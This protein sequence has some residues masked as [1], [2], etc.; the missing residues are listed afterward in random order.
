VFENHHLIA[1]VAIKG[2][3]QI[4]TT[5]LHLPTRKPHFGA[6]T[7]LLSL[8]M[9]ELLPFEFAVGCNAFFF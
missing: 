8:K 2:L 1:M 4:L 6:N 3:R 5:P 7:L 9:P